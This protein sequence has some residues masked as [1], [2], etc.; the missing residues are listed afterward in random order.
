MPGFSGD[1]LLPG[2]TGEGLKATA[3]VEDGRLTLSCAA[4][5]LGSWV[6]SEIEVHRDDGA[7]ILEM[8]GEKIVFRPEEIEGFARLLPSRS[9]PRAPR[10]GRTIRLKERILGAEARTPE[11]T[12]P[13]GGDEAEPTEIAAH[14]DEAE[15]TPTQP[16]AGY[17]VPERL[18]PPVGEEGDPWVSGPLTLGHEE[19]DA[20]PPPDEPESS[21]PL[22]PRRSS[23]RTS[24][25]A[26]RVPQGLATVVV[27]VLVAV[28]LSAAA[29]LLLRGGSSSTPEAM[30]PVEGSLDVTAE[31]FRSRWN[32]VA[33][34]EAPRLILGP[35]VVEETSEEVRFR[36][37]FHEDLV[38]VGWL[39]D[40]RLRQASVVA[41]PGGAEDVLGMVDAWHLLLAATSESLDRAGRNRILH[42]LAAFGP[43]P[44]GAVALSGVRYRLTTSPALGTWLTVSR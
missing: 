40:G 25:S 9:S 28:V 17:P 12:L 39:Q 44:G 34:L 29:A 35:L 13:S 30:L 4:G 18:D 15:T 5:Q 43:E 27:F 36:H 3:Y 23:R 42:E 24:R 38:L 31:E 1:L 6:V 37:R 11:E 41:T 19:P 14:L 21:P 8:E 33:R 22:A 26:L 20:P 16:V 7:F 32:R 10:G 2:E